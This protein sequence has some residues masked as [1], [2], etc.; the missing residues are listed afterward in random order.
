MTHASIYLR[1]LLLCLLVWLGVGC[2][3]VPGVDAEVG[4]TVTAK[5]PT[6]T[7][8]PSPTAT[9]LPTFTPYPTIAIPML[10]PT[11]TPTLAATATPQPTPMPQALGLPVQV[12]PEPFGVEIHFTHPLEGEMEKLVAG[13]FKFVRM[14]LFWSEIERQP[15]VYNFEAYDSL[16]RTLR[17]HNLRLIFIL[18]YNN[19]FHDGGHSP[20]T[21]A[22]RAA[23]VRFVKTAVRRYRGNDIIWEVWNEPNLPK[24]W[25]PSPN[26]TN[27][28]RLAIA[29]SDAIHQVDP[30]AWVVGPSTSGFDRPFWEE[31]ARI[32]ALKHFDAISIHPYRT[33]MPETAL[34]DY[35]W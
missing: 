1:W 31:M 35:L 15:G 30:T 12:I 28:A 3:G 11:I 29:V 16:V 34:E 22:G 23:F 9:P 13:G 7:P 2:R 19:T 8:T 27:Y 17:R 26:A 32:G 5:P 10:T 21:D 24:F 4:A 33:T 6:L 14:D 18:D 25:S 20:H